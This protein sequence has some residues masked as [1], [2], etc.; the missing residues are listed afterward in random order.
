MGSATACRD[1]G[2]GVKAWA[3]PTTFRNLTAHSPR[4]TLFR[5]YAASLPSHCELVHVK[6]LAALYRASGF[7]CAAPWYAF[8]SLTKFSWLAANPTLFLRHIFAH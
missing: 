4:S 3:N 2:R 6:T 7:C 5:T 8:G 1:M